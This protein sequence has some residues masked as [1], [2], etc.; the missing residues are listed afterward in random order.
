VRYL[1]PQKALVAVVAVSL[2]GNIGLQLA[3]PQLLRYFIDEALSGSP[4]GRLVAVAVLFTVVALV[5]QVFNV[6]ATY[7]SGRVGWTATNALRADLA[8]HCLHLDMSF[9]NNRT[10]G[11]MIERI[12]GD[13]E[14]LGSFFSTFVIHV[15]GSIILLV[16]I[17]F[18]LFREDWR[19]GLALT[20]FATVVLVVLFR[21]RNLTV[22]RFRAVREASAQTFGF[23]EERL[24]GREDIRTSAARSYVMLG[25]H[26]R[27]RDWFRKNLKASLMISLVLN[28]TWFS[29]AVA[30]AV[31][32]G[33]GSWLFLNGHVTIGT[34][35]LIVHY[36]HMLLQPIERFTQELNN[37]QKATASVIRILDL[38]Q[39][40]RQVLDGPGVRFPGGAL[41][42]RF[43]GVSFAYKPGE[44]VL[45]DIS[46]EL[47]PGRV[48]GLIGR[49]GSGKTTITRLLFRL[50]DPDEGRVLLGGQ[51]VRDARIA[52]L[53]EQVGVVTQDVRLFEGTVRDNL[54]LL[55]RGI[56]DDRLIEVVEEL[57]LSRWFRSLDQGLD[58][59]MRSGGAGLSAGEAQLLAFARV[60]LR[61]PRVVVLDEASSR[62][63]PVTAQLIERSV[64]RLVEGR[65]V[66][67]IAHRLATLD[68]CDEIMILERGRIVEHGARSRLAEDPNTRFHKL[69]K[70]DMGEV[71]A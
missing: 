25:F 57:G 59:V 71:L 69:L 17:L 47:A 26:S 7:T 33:V 11:E 20:T 63:D 38:F 12:D 39:T 31:A 18:L 6:V 29:F 50:Y 24:A 61:D 37:L 53:R 58:S 62:I 1:R 65:T 32:L 64:D 21:L 9:H 4:V 40:E 44:P 34:V 36:T 41:P 54:T 45:Q 30:N 55:D 52:E 56:P 8:R 16:G 51:D 35:F 67:V 5:Q 22:D 10:P 3:N 70:T 13:S 60:F 27:I 2:L 28:T 48:M 46:F 19:A 14:Q 42:V 49:T 23:I 66:I 15:L 68:R 43:D